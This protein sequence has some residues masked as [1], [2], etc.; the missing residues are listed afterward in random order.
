M[1][2]FLYNCVVFAV[3]CACFLMNE[4]ELVVKLQ[5]LVYCFIFV[6]AAVVNVY[7]CVFL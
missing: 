7:I 3:F 4:D 2:E 1:V 5:I 6:V